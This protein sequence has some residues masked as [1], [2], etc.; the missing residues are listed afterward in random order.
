MTVFFS[1]RIKGNRLQIYS[2]EFAYFSAELLR[3]SGLT[4]S[5]TGVRF[6]VHTGK[7]RRSL[8]ITPAMVGYKLGAFIE[9]RKFFRRSG[10]Q[11]ERLLRRRILTSQKN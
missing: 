8:R 9:T 10:G 11:K 7:I 1:K 3:S 5:L 6:P 4:S 2:R